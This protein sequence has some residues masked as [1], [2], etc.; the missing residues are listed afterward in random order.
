MPSLI[1]VGVLFV[2]LLAAATLPKSAPTDSPPCPSVNGGGTKML[3]TYRYVD[4]TTDVSLRIWK[5]SINLPT[6]AVSQILLVSDTTVCRR[7][8][9]AYN[10]QLAG[11]SLPA[12]SSVNVL[13]YG[14]IRYIIADPS[15]ISSGA[16]R[17]L[18]T[19]T[20]FVRLA[21]AGR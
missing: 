20:A 13:S 9:T 19:D 3:D 18:V 5:Q 10:A 7:A 21:V 14:A 1:P 12:S 11:D 6:V 16:T 15:R 4:T 17:E 2:G 8:I